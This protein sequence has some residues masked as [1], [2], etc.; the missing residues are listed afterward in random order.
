M[1]PKLTNVLGQVLRHLPWCKRFK[2]SND[3]VLQ[4]K[5]IEGATGS[6]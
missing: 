4:L 6:H 1:F 2:G 5:Q 3:S